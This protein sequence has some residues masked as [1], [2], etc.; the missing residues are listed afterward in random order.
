MGGADPRFRVVHDGGGGG[1]GGGWNA[2]ARHVFP[3]TEYL[4][5]LAPDDVLLPRAYEDLIGLLDKSGADLATGNVYRL[6][7]AGRSQ[8]AFH[9]AARET[10]LRTHVRRDPVLLGDHFVRNKVFRRAF[11]DRHG[12]VFPDGDGC[13]GAAVALPAHVLAEAVD[14]LHEHVCYWRLPSGRGG[15]GGRGRRR[16]GTGSRRWRGCGRCWP[17]RCTGWTPGCGRRTTGRS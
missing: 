16:C 10:V 14:V 13:D 11:W 17:I 2:G 12:F 6:G 7:A 8:S 15:P 5:F 3:H 9:P 4:A 1:R